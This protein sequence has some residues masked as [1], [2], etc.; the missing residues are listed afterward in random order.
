MRITGHMVKD[1][2]L[3]RRVKQVDFARHFD[4]TKQAVHKWEKEGLPEDRIESFMAW[5]IYGAS[6]HS[7]HLQNKN[8]KKS[9]NP[10]VRTE[11]FT[12]GETN[13]TFTPGS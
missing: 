3:A 7:A 1:A 10:Q 13:G 11:G 6:S 5:L 2:R 12:E 8:N 9:E 4:V